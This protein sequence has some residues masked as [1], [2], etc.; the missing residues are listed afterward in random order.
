[1][2]LENDVIDDNYEGDSDPLAD[3][4]SADAADAGQTGEEP[5]PVEPADSDQPDTGND[6]PP[7]TGV[8]AELAGTPFKTVDAL[9][10]S[11][12][13][14]QR[15]VAD[16]DNRLKE[17]EKRLDSTAAS[18]QQF[19]GK[20][21]EPESQIPKGQDFWNALAKDPE[22]LINMLIQHQQEKFYK[23]K[24]DPRLGQVEGTMSGYQRQRMV[25]TFIAAHPEFTVE[26]EAQ[27]VD[28]L[29][30]N[31][32]MKERPDG[33]ELAYNSILANRYRDGA[34]KTAG[35]QAVAGAKA[36]AGVAGK[37]TALPVG[38][39]S[40]KDPFDEVLEEDKAARELFKLGRK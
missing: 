3:E 27:V 13:N 20:K 37:K 10:N 14:I 36:V 35:R 34:K 28:V 5:E 30:A 4:P 31:P 25:E 8:P 2:P 16:K 1:M 39:Q 24:V 17:M 29:D 26:D 33:I 6:T 22:A 23:E 7:D 18:I 32:W 40:E 9:V 11:Y 21:G 19:F 12:K 15:L 38:Q